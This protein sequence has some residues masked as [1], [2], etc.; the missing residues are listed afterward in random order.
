[1]RYL[2]GQWTATRILRPTLTP[3]GYPSV[4][5]S[6]SADQHTF[7][8]HRLVAES[9]LPNPENK[10]E[11]THRNGVRAD[12]R[13]ENLEWVTHKES[14]AHSKLQPERR[15]FNVESSISGVHCPGKGKAE[16][17]AK[18]ESQG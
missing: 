12:N 4:G 7:L 2:D 18:A 15:T 14:C 11:V 13:V 5:L 1:M 10:P 16:D 6:Y 8:V 9:F 3:A 17:E